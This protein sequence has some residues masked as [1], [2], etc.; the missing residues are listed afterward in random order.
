MWTRWVIPA[1]LMLLAA[2]SLLTLRSV[3]PELV[4]RQL[5]FFLAGALIFWLTR[6]V[7]FQTWVTLRWS[8]FGMLVTGL[9]IT[10]LVGTITRGTKS[11]IPIGSF[12]IQPSQLAVPIMAL[13][14]AT[15]IDK[16]GLHKAKNILLAAALF[17]IPAAFILTEPDLGTSII[18][19]V[20]MLACFW[21][22][23]VPL[24][25]VG[26][27]ILGGI[28]VLAIGWQMLRPYQRDRLI[29]FMEPSQDQETSSAVYH[30]QQSMIAVGSGG[31]LGR[32]LGEGIQSHLRF[33]PERQTDFV[34]ASWAEE[35]G[36]LGTFL[37]IAIYGVC[38]MW[39]V[40]LALSSSRIT[41][42]LFVFASVTM[43]VSQIFVNIGM[44][45]GLLPITGITLPMISYG[46]SSILSLCF[47]FGCLQSLLVSR[48]IHPKLTIS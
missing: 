48:P 26:A 30:A 22:G 2:V 7:N 11:W 32:G 25:W 14:L 47:H 3:A 9:T 27:G 5:L 44:N 19:I 24:K 1:I 45:M 28:V 16:N 36:L 38:I 8:L 23:G 13:V 33:L 43:L 4:G 37:V 6:Q 46:G 10:Q 39:L 15:L 29:G 17:I 12:H 34:F 18:Y 21:V 31:V 41:E 42:K 35:T 20:S 40:N